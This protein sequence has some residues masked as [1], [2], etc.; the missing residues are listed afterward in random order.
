AELLRAFT[1]PIQLM[2]D[3]EA[4]E[5]IAGELVETKAAEGVRYLEIRW[6]PGLHTARGLS[7]R[8][9]IAAV[10]RGS[11]DAARRTGVDVRLI[12]TAMRSADPETNVELARVAADAM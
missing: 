2:Q 7:L 8:D 6:A 3:A 4:L 12:C 9:G 1:I 5:R 10:A 11:N